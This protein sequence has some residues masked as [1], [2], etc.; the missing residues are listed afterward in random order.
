MGIWT[1]EGRYDQISD[2]HTERQGLFGHLLRSSLAH[3]RSTCIHYYRHHIV[4]TALWS[5]HTVLDLKETSSQKNN[6]SIFFLFPRATANQ[7]QWDV[8]LRHP[9]VFYVDANISS[10]QTCSVLR[11]HC[12]SSP[13]SV[14]LHQWPAAGQ[15]SHVHSGLGACTLLDILQVAW[16]ENSINKY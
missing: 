9:V 7:S 2:F 14:P 11:P 13:R 16:R 12:A 6:A 4:R 5:T 10:H 1:A 8:T 3:G 15:R